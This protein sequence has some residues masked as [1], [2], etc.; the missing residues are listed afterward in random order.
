MQ[1]HT[2]SEIKKSQNA[3]L[4]RTPAP[5]PSMYQM[6]SLPASTNI[7]PSPRQRTFYNPQKSIQLVYLAHALPLNLAHPPLPRTIPRVPALRRRRPLHQGSKRRPS[8]LLRSLPDSAALIFPASAFAFPQDLGRHAFQ[9][10]L[11]PQRPV[12]S[13]RVFLFQLSPRRPDTRAHLPSPP[14]RGCVGG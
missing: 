10:L 1:R 3:P 6:H 4:L 8:L 2:T 11:Q 7:L 5:S 9:A 14:R 12:A 13:L